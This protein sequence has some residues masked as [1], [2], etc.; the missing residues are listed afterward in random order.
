M[1]VQIVNKQESIDSAIRKFEAKC[2]R[3]HI[4]KLVHQK[5]Y[6]VSKSEIRHRKKSRRSKFAKN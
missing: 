5:S 4:Y 3:A 2:R 6:F 1:V